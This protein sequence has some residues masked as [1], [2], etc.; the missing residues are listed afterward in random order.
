MTLVAIQ[1]GKL[2]SNAAP[3]QV[4]DDPIAQT[5]GGIVK[6]RQL[7]VAEKTQQ[8]RCAGN[9]NLGASWT[10]AGHLATLF[11]ITHPKIVIE[12]LNLHG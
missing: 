9:N 4:R 11:Q 12:D 5:G 7:K 10:D 6:R 8:N 3:C 2:G 1:L